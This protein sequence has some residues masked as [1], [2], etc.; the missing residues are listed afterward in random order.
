VKS[1]SVRQENCECCNGDPVAI[2]ADERQ[3]RNF[4]LPVAIVGWRDGAPPRVN[5]ANTNP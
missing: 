4:R 2:D 5:P 1:A 3:L